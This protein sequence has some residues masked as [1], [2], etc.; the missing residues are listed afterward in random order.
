MVSRRKS[1][2]ERFKFSGSNGERLRL[3]SHRSQISLEGG[4]IAEASIDVK[5]VA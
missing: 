4:H 2:A 3:T 1:S 5:G